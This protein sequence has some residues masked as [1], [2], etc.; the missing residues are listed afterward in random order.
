MA[1]EK[2]GGPP[3]MPGDAWDDEGRRRRLREIDQQ[4]LAWYPGPMPRS[5]VVL[6]DV[7]P[8]TIH[9]YWSMDPDYLAGFRQGETDAE[10]TPLALRLHEMGDEGCQAD[11]ALDGLT[12]NGYFNLSGAGG[13]YVGQLGVHLRGGFL[14]VALSRPVQLPPAGPAEPWPAETSPASDSPAASILPEGPSPADQN[15]P[16]L[17]QGAGAAPPRD[18]PAP[19][20]GPASGAS[21]EEDIPDSEKPPSDRLRVEQEE[22]VRVH[23]RELTERAAAGGLEWLLVDESPEDAEPQDSIEDEPEAALEA[24]PPHPAG[25]DIDLPGAPRHLPRSTVLEVARRAA[26]AKATRPPP[27]LLGFKRRARRPQGWSS[28]SLAQGPERK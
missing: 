22:L 12:N 2:A 4:L 9:A 24:A 26:R 19:E 20:G 7:D 23:Y 6:M 16:S 3:A 18:L 1:E 15:S 5:C 27:P 8:G 17:R 28:F 11:V 10:K 13:V 14:P 25:E 21:F